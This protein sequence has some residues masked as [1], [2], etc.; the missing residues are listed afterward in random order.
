MNYVAQ[1]LS[2][3][4][5]A[6]SAATTTLKNLVNGSGL[7]FSFFLGTILIFLLL[8]IVFKAF[9]SKALGGLMSS[10]KADRGDRQPR[11]EVKQ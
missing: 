1:V 7:P 2:I 10:G 9:R 11:K 4:L 5:E 3:L 8:T 6:L